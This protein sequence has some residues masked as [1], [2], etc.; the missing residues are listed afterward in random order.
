MNPVALRHASGRGWVGVFTGFVLGGSLFA[1]VVTQPGVISSTA[2]GSS[3]KMA[4]FEQEQL[5]LNQEF[6]SLVSQGAT[7]EQLEAWQLQNPPEFEVHPQL[8]MAVAV[9][10]ALKPLPVIEWVVFP[11]NASTTMQDYMT[12]RATLANAFAQI[13]NQLLQ[14]M[15]PVATEAELGTMQGQEQQTFVQQNAENLQLQNQ[16]AQAVAAASTSVAAPILGPPAIPAGASPQLQA[17]LTAQNALANA[18]A[19]VWNQYL[20]ADPTTAQAAMQQWAQQNADSFQ[21]LKQLAQDLA[22]STAN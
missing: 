13:H 4:Q 20:M 8:A 21:Q 19:Q 6:Q 14:G 16:Q 5:A 18:Q 10:S 11:A 22:N 2:S 12:T 15:L 17:Y 7:A 1:Q 3:I 9:A